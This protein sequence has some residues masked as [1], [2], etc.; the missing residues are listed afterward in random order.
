[1][2]IVKYQAQ[3]VHQ[4]LQVQQVQLVLME[5]Q[6]LQVHQEQAVLQVH[7]ALQVQ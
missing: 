7:Q 2:E 1:M 3:V 5:H 6:M 4:E